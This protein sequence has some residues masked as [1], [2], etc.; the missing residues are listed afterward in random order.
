MAK[1]LRSEWREFRIQP[2]ISAIERGPTRLRQAG[3]SARRITAPVNGWRLL[4]MAALWAACQ[5][6]GQPAGA[7]SSPNKV[8]DESRWGAKLLRIIADC[9]RGSPTRTSSLSLF[10]ESCILNG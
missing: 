8:A 3:R 5:G 1:L 9:D 10:P 7:P 4:R 2:A 6:R